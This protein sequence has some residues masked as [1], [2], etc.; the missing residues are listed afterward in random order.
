MNA[1]NLK[2]QAGIGLMIYCKMLPWY[3]EEHAKKEIHQEY[4]S[5]KVLWK[6]SN[7]SYFAKSFG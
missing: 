2:E 6:N 5:I 1:C 7:E 4:A 3:D